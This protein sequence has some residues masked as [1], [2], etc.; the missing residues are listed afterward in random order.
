MEEN[1]RLLS[2]RLSSIVMSNK[3]IMEVKKPPYEMNEEK[4]K[5]KINLYL[6]FRELLEF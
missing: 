2:S 5:K 4:R 6:L 3:T 1:T